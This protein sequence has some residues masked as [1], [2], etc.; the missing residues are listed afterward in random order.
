MVKIHAADVLE[1]RM[2]SEARIPGGFA[3]DSFEDD[4][5]FEGWRPL[6]AWNRP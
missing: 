1:T 2:A 6:P 4:L 3:E 5:D